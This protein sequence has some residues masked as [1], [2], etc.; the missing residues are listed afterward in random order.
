MMAEG[1]DS[2]VELW[3]ASADR[4]QAWDDYAAMRGKG[5]GSCRWY[6]SQAQEQTNNYRARAAA[7]R[8][9]AASMRI[10]AGLYRLK[11]LK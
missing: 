1:Y 5:V 9:K 7:E 11:P 6:I 3:N 10:E 8:K 2:Q 4:W